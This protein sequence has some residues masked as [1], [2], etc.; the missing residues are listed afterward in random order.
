MAAAATQQL[1]ERVI[2]S[3]LA[4]YARRR[5]T[6]GPYADNLDLDVLIVGAG[7]SGIYLLYEMRKQ[8]YNTTLYDAGT[9]FGGTW[10]WNCY[11]GARVDS[12]VPIYQLAIPEVYNTWSFTTNYPDWQEL[13]AYFDYVDKVCDLSKDT[14]FETVVTS[15]EFDEQAGKWTVKTAD[16]RTA[17]TRFLIIAAGFASKRYIP[18][19]KSMDNFKG[20]VHHSSFWPPEDVDVKG[21]RV[22]VVGT[23]ASGV[24]IAQEW[25]PQ[26]EHLTLFQRTPNLALPMGKRPMSKEEQ[27]GLRPYYKEMLDLR[28]R[29][30]AGFTYDFAEHDT[31]DHTPEERE[32]FFESLWKR[33]GFALWLGGY[34]D[35]LFEM[36]ANREAYN[37]WAKKQRQR[38]KNP[39]KRDL[40]CPLEPPHAFGIKRPCLE[41]NYYEVLDQDNVDIVDISEK[42][43]NQIVEFTETGIKTADGKVHEVDVVALAT[44]F[45]IT[46]GGMT[47][48][49]LKSVNGTYLKDEWKAS[50]NTYLGTTIS[51]YPNMFH[52][53]GPHGPTLLSNGPS[54]VEIQGRWIRDAINLINK[55]GL[56]SINATPEATNAWKQRINDLSNKTLM[57]TTRSTYMGGSVPGKAFE[58]VNYA[59]GVDKYRGE[60]REVLKDWRGFKTVPLTA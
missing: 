21:K 30:F 20:V 1:P 35:Y 9:G 10:R 19:Y 41:Q 29:C 42:G 7:F 18:D 2:K 22:A 59:G 50:A 53:Y 31:F 32:A 43:G 60:I 33:A 45:D 12:P 47:S 48:M 39:A 11:P 34:K 6:T 8:G 40:L 5:D 25:G 28:E 49:G 56:K 27:D 4:Q 44:G 14:A 3:E 37:F 15:A 46:T 24:Q 36:K 26:V 13:Q 17:K 16:G 51:G 55:Q 23:G 57:P 58:Q 54:S 52:V 38:I